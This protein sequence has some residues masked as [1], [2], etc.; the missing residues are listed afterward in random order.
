[1]KKSLD[2]AKLIR[3][4]E[5]GAADQTNSHGMGLLHTLIEAAEEDCIKLLLECGVD[6]KRPTSDASHRTPLHL[7]VER[8]AG[9]IVRLLLK[10]GAD[11]KVWNASRRVLFLFSL[12]WFFFRLRIEPLDG[13]LLTSQHLWVLLKF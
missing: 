5:P 9:D 1:M 11:H 13:L 12:L 4:R 8:G 2:V 3:T 6:V 7:A 10:A